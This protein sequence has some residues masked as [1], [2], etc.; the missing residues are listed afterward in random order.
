M[1]HVNAAASERLRILH[2][3]EV[4]WGGVV[5]LLG[6]FVEQQFLDGHDVHVLAHPGMPS[7]HPGA[8]VHQWELDRARPRS[9]PAARRELHRLVGV[10]EPDV[11]HLHSWFAGALGRTPPT[12]RGAGKVPV[13]YQPHAW[14]DRLSSRPG[15]A[16]AVRA[17]ERFFA[18]HTDVLVVNCE[19][20]LNRGRDLGV[21]TP[22]HSL[23]VAVD[24]T[25]FRPPTQVERCAARA[26]LG[27]P[28]GRRL[29][30]VLGRLTW[31]KGQDLLVPAWVAAPAPDTTLALVGPGDPGP[32]A[33]LAGGENGRSV[34]LPG[35]TDEVL[36][37]LWAADVMVLSSRYETVALVIAEAMSTGLPVVA[38]AVDGAEEV[39]QGGPEDPA[40]TVVPLDDMGGLVREFSHRLDDPVLHAHESAAGP[41]RARE[42]FAPHVVARRLEAAYWDAIHQ[43]HAEKR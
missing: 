4:H 17:S 42:L 6:H 20:E 19:D 3:S 22:G 10:L 27:I 33:L 2:V 8:I 7:L 15:A 26:L 29:A 32:L 30:L 18:R 31:Q 24:L 40:G 11:V 1:H 21:W 9:L 37:W 14:S 38:T 34:I 25:R 28:E 13:V 5:T 16:L 36:P 35:G 43:H 41:V 12:L 23:G 39:L